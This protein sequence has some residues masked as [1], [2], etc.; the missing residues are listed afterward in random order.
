MSK[1][2]KSWWLLQHST[3]ELPSTATCGLLLSVTACLALLLLLVLVL[4]QALPPAPLTLYTTAHCSSSSNM[5]ACF[6]EHA[7]FQNDI[8]TPCSRSWAQG[9][10]EQ[11]NSNQPNHCKRTFTECSPTGSRPYVHCERCATRTAANAETLSRT[12]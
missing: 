4:L 5:H 12:S 11:C 3:C 9:A 6:Q 10:A 7:C 2:C 8:I 1:T